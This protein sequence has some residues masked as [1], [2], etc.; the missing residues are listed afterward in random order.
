[1]KAKIQETEIWKELCKLN[2]TARESAF[3]QYTSQIESKLSCKIVNHPFVNLGQI[4]NPVL[5][6][7]D[8]FLNIC[9]LKEFVP[10]SNEITTN[11]NLLENTK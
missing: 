5:S 3:E 11:Q 6:V 1:M 7:Q 8:R 2:L 4:K 9:Y 10:T